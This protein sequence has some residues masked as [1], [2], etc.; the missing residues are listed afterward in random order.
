MVRDVESILEAVFLNPMFRNLFCNLGE[1]FKPSQT[2]KWAWTSV[3]GTSIMC[4]GVKGTL[5]QF[6]ESDC[7]PLCCCCS[8]FPHSSIFGFDMS[9]LW[10]WYDF[11][12]EHI[13]RK[14]L[15]FCVFRIVFT[16]V[17]GTEGFVLKEKTCY[18]KVWLQ[19]L[20][21][22]PESLGRVWGLLAYCFKR[23]CAWLKVWIA[24]HCSWI[25][26]FPQRPSTFP[27]PLLT[28]CPHHYHCANTGAQLGGLN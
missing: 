28:V 22:L 18:W 3:S 1:M 13:Y 15:F 10:P 26:E 17:W 19:R 20:N 27:F 5:P 7:F 23:W 14:Y 16:W 9:S 24:G 6:G 4:T 12:Q 21:I 25:R 8:I 2:R 11:V